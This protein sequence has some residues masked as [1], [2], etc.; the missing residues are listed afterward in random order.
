VIKCRS[1]GRRLQWVKPIGL[2]DIYLHLLLN[3]FVTAEHIGQRFRYGF[4]STVDKTSYHIQ[5]DQINAML[6]WV[7]S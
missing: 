3:T 1:N 4:S 5:G 6:S 7:N 2:P